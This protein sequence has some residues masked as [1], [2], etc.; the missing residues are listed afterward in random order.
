MKTHRL[1]R[2]G[3]TTRRRGR[4]GRPRTRDATLGGSRETPDRRPGRH[5]RI[6]ERPRRRTPRV[7]PRARP[8]RRRHRRQSPALCICR[9]S[10]LTEPCAPC[11]AGRG[12]QQYRNWALGRKRV[13]G[14]TFFSQRTRLV[15]LVCCR[16]LEADGP[17]SR[18]LRRWNW[19]EYLTLMFSSTWSFIKVRCNHLRSGRQEEVARTQRIS[20]GPTPTLVRRLVSL[21]S[22]RL[23]VT[24]RPHRLT[25][26]P[27]SLSRSQP[28][29]GRPPRCGG[30]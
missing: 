21:V 25:R 24:L 7:C 3:L 23:V 8:R 27:S 30:A 20:L 19:W 28:P 4:S 10:P 13:S 9:P 29:G 2:P 6:A 22:S 17:R 11:Y 12:I 18:P 26:R 14:S 15:C 1:R 16:G 5:P